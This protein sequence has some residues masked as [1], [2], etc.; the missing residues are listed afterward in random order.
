MAALLQISFLL[1]FSKPNSGEKRPWANPGVR[2]ITEGF[3]VDFKWMSVLF[4]RGFNHEIVQG[5]QHESSDVLEPRC[6]NLS[7]FSTELNYKSAEDYV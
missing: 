6:S 5:T 2:S 1:P 4:Q 7:V 3:D